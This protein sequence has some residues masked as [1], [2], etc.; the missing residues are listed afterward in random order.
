MK[1]VNRDRDYSGVV[2]GDA[3]P[4]GRKLGPLPGFLSTGQ[5]ARRVLKQYDR[6]TKERIEWIT[7]R[8]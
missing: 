3:K 7:V 6:R 1:A 2:C 4:D 5:P 8:Q